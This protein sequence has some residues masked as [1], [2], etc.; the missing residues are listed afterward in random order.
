MISVS[1]D[2]HCTDLDETHPSEFTVKIPDSNSRPPDKSGYWKMIFL[3][4]Q[5]KHMLW[6]L[7][8]TS[9]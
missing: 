9:Q 1:E 8:R 5:P 2:L 4:T 7:K 6:V 3:I